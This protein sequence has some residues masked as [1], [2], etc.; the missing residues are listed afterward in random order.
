MSPQPEPPGEDP[1]TDTSFDTE[2]L[3]ISQESAS[4]VKIKGKAGAV[5]KQQISSAQVRVINLE[6][7]DPVIEAPTDSTGAFEVEL[8]G[9]QSDIFRLQLRSDNKFSGASDV[10]A[11]PDGSVT[12]AKGPLSNCL[13]LYPDQQNKRENEM[14]FAS[15][16][17][18]ATATSSYDLENNCDSAVTIVQYKLRQSDPNYTFVEPP[19]LT[20]DPSKRTNIRIDF[21]P[22]TEGLLVDTALLFVDGPK[23]DRIA[24][25]LRGLGLAQ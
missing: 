2:N 6:T 25:S 22:Q 21:E 20:L 3:V 19:S 16:A 5:K 15:T 24:V 1:D 7:A 14:V 4:T 23:Q 9:K 8:A 17:V 10:N 18:G 12:I 11:Q 13:V